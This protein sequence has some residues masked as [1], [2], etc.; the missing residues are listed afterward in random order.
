MNSRY[1]AVVSL[2]ILQSGNS[3][4]DIDLPITI[5]YQDLC[6]TK[7]TVIDLALNSLP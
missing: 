5:Q 3:I 6:A 7:R 4:E 2:L 1:N